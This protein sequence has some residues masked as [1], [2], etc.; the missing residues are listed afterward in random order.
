MLLLQP[1][2]NK[3]NN[4]Q[5]HHIPNLLLRAIIM[6]QPLTKGRE[7][8]K[9]IGRAP[10]SKQVNE[11]FDMWVLPPTTAD[12]LPRTVQ[13]E[14]IR[15]HFGDNMSER[16]KSQTITRP[17]MKL[18]VQHLVSRLGPH[19]NTASNRASLSVI[20]ETVVVERKIGGINSREEYLELCH[21]SREAESVFFS[22]LQGT[23]QKNLGALRKTV[24]DM[25]AKI[26][27]AD[28]CVTDPMIDFVKEHVFGREALAGLSLI[29]RHDN[30]LSDCFDHPCPSRKGTLLSFVNETSPPHLTLL[31]GHAR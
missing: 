19:F 10:L 28:V 14:R 21:A 17:L 13:A 25:V 20:I 8:W 9:R 26:F 5:H 30:M 23:L 15:D 31:C 27:E 11:I 12:F 1:P 4:N 29:S 6:R 24:R 7:S 22:K 16:L 18:S 3:T 2:P